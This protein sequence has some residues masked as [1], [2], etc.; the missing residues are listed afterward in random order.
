MES[1]L[2]TYVSCI[3]IGNSPIIPPLLDDCRREEMRYY[4]QL[5]ISLETR[6]KSKETSSDTGATSS[7]ESLPTEKE[8]VSRIDPLIDMKTDDL[9]GVELEHLDLDDSDSDA[10]HEPSNSF[11]F[12]ESNVSNTFDEPSDSFTL[13][14]NTLPSTRERSNSYTLETPSPVLLAFIRSLQE[15][16]D[17]SQDIFTDKR[18]DTELSTPTAVVVEEAP[19]TESLKEKTRR[20]LWAVHLPSSKPGETL[21]QSTSLPNSNHVSP[22]KPI[23]RS[24]H[25][26][27]GLVY[28]DTYLSNEDREYIE[29]IEQQSTQT[30]SNTSTDITPTKYQAPFNANDSFAKDFNVLDI[31][32]LSR[33]TDIIGRESTGTFSDCSSVSLGKFMP[34]V[35]NKKSIDC[36]EAEQEAF[37]YF[38]EQLKVKHRQQLAELLQV[39]QREHDMLKEQFLKLSRASSCVKVSPPSTPL[40][41]YSH[42]TYTKKSPNKCTVLDESISTQLPIPNSSSSPKKRSSS[43]Q[44]PIHRRHQAASKIQAGVRGY[45]TRRLFK[46]SRVVLL[47]QTIKDC[48][49]TAVSLQNETNLGLSELDLQN[50]LLQQLTTACNE[51][52]DIFS[53]PV[54]DR[55]AIIAEDRDKKKRESRRSNTPL[56]LSEATRRSLQRKLTSSVPDGDRKRSRKRCKSASSVRSDSSNNTPPTQRR[57]LTATMSFSHKYSTSHSNRKPWR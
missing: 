25:S 54:K 27:D 26:D 48:L 37:I 52:N 45:F 56:P 17:E 7:S 46:T 16:Q 49:V 9:D 24:S 29:K 19:R 33:D 11:T 23:K 6:F 41:A 14:E 10:S 21:T 40:A 1:Y 20:K 42:D 2:G 13:A 3:K 12:A 4:R 31:S 39:Q 18:S 15:K 30:D 53:L 22:S 36:G 57:P 44:S 5:A 43:S 50:R 55:L 38:Q 47:V 34:S 32:V 51:L 35:D 28:Q 8:L